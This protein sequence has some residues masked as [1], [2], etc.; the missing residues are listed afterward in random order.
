MK[1]KIGF[2]IP[3]V[4]CAFLSLTALFMP[5]LFP[6]GRDGHVPVAFF[7][8]LPMCFFFVGSALW[9]MHREV[10]SLRERLAQ[11]EQLRKS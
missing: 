7:A 9:Q 6:R 1:Q 11:L 8:F 2:W 3:A 5:L 10:Q 4:F